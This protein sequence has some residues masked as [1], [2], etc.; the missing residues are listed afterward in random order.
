MYSSTCNRS[1]SDF[2]TVFLLSSGY[3]FHR[4]IGRLKHLAN[5]TSWAMFSA[6]A[7]HCVQTPMSANLHIGSL[8]TSCLLSCRSFWIKSADTGSFTSVRRS[9]RC[10]ASKSGSSSTRINRVSLTSRAC[11]KSWRPRISGASKY[12]P[13]TAGS[14][15]LFSTIAPCTTPCCPG[16]RAGGHLR[17]GT[18]A[19]R[20]TRDWGVVCLG[21]FG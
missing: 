3:S 13:A 2:G 17:T 18:L 11:R 14:A 16:R 6:V 5:S 20:H 1:K 12:V 9:R 15:L 19:R 21:V 10:A 4:I 7:S 8:T